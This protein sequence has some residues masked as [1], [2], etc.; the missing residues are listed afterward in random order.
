MDS[1]TNMLP[2]YA[3]NGGLLPPPPPTDATAH[4][5]IAHNDSDFT[6]GPCI[7]T[8]CTS[9]PCTPTHDD[10]SITDDED[11]TDDES[12][13][14]LIASPADIDAFVIAADNGKLTPDGVTTAVVTKGI[15]VNGRHSKY[16]LTALHRA[17]ANSRRELVAAL[18]AAGANPYVKDHGDR[19]SVWKAAAY[20]TAEILQLLIGSDGCVN[21]PNNYGQTPLMALVMC[22]DVDG[23]AARLEVLL[24]CPKLDLDATY[25]GKTA[26]EWA[27]M[28]GHPQLADAIAVQRRR[29]WN[30]AATAATHA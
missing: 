5:S 11:I 12:I 3:P 23:A 17:V 27:V 28:V 7:P 15:P 20:G 4:D 8:P 13:N 22:S 16:G 30:A 9:T 25:Y 19:T 29:A 1:C 24:A 10:E 2:S 18:L 6:I 21:E 26:E 14:A